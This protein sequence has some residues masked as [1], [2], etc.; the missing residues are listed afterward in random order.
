M[1]A[2]VF[3]LGQQ[4]DTKKD[5]REKERTKKKHKSKKAGGVAFDV[6]EQEENVQ[7]EDSEHLHDESR[8][9]LTS[10]LFKFSSNG[11]EK[12]SE[13]MNE[14]E[15]VFSKDQ[16]R[17]SAINEQEHPLSVRRQSF[18][19][20]QLSQA[21][22]TGSM[23]MVDHVREND[24][25]S[26]HVSDHLSHYSVPRGKARPYSGGK[27]VKSVV[28]QE[29]EPI[30]YY[31]SSYPDGPADTS[32]DK[33]LPEEEDTPLFPLPMQQKKR[34]KNKHSRKQ[35]LSGGHKSHKH[36]SHRKSRRDR[37]EGNDKHE[38]NEKA[39]N[40]R[41]QPPPPPPPNKLLGQDNTEEMGLLLKKKAFPSDTQSSSLRLSQAYEIGE[42]GAYHIDD[43]DD[44][45]LSI[46]SR[47]S[48]SVLNRQKRNKA[49]VI[50]TESIAGS[51]N[52]NFQIEGRLS[53]TT[54]VSDSKVTVRV[55]EYVNDEEDFPRT[56]NP[57]FETYP[58]QPKDLLNAEDDNSSNSGSAL[59]LLKP[60]P[61]RSALSTDVLG[62]IKNGATLLRAA[63]QAPPK[64]VDLRTD[65]LSA[66]KSGTQKLRTVDPIERRAAPAIEVYHP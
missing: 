8:N 5:P 18:T 62:G 60:Q 16:F 12:Q 3:K 6:P 9:T 47:M 13:R 22:L 41:N 43:E 28:E 10:R 53:N 63:P 64:K 14:K 11:I 54:A 65:I 19:H 4:K 56:G 57:D 33:L 48:A 32:P 39:S 20:E 23:D 50:T 49:L 55:E 21:I 35:Q 29:Q 25:G 51:V 36:R 24:A 27:G 45:S 1:L 38:D 61:P 46:L 59:L 31:A 40:K 7:R 44:E 42:I 17:D 34:K 2:N 58:A 66:I 26:S 52:K 15:E 37:R 30:G